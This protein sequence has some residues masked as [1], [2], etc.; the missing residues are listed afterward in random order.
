MNDYYRNMYGVGNDVSSKEMTT[1]AMEVYQQNDNND[2]YV[3]S[4][5]YFL[6]DVNEKDTLVKHVVIILSGL[7]I[8]ILFCSWVYTL[9]P[10]ITNISNPLKIPMCIPIFVVSFVGSYF[11]TQTKLIYSVRFLSN[12]LWNKQEEE[13]IEKKHEKRESPKENDFKS[14]EPYITKQEPPRVQRIIPQVQSYVKDDVFENQFDTSLNM[15]H[16]SFSNFQE[17]IETDRR[18]INTALD[19]HRDS[20]NNS[21]NVPYQLDGS[22]H[23]DRS[24]PLWQIQNQQENY[25]QMPR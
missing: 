3:S 25:A 1:V 24:T 18:T 14:L 12:Q 5:N 19:L 23:A 8:A 13:I 2:K 6:P 22:Q 16:E 11:V 7:T 20:F 17:K 10:R 15:S 21:Q 9:S 4:L